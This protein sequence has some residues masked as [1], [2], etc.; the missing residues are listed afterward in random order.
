MEIEGRIIMILPL[1]SGVSKS[2][3][4]WKKQD[5]ILETNHQQYPK[6]V[7]FNL[8]GEKIDQFA[9]TEGESVKVS[10]DIE[11]REYNGRWYTDVRAWNVERV[12]L[13]GAIDPMG[14][15]M[16]APVDF[17]AHSMADNNGTMGGFNAMSN[18]GDDLPF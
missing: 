12:S 2:G 8:W 18:A 13:E 11:S 9:L 16:G 4:E 5:Y 7:C 3:N 6:K 17:S 1:N 15:A 14:A 10:I